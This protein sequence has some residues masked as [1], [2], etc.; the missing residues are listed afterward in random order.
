MIAIRLARPG[1]SEAIAA[2]YVPIVRDTV[3]SFEID[4]PTP[5]EMRQRIAATLV[6]H[7][8]LV[9]EQ[10]GAVVGYAYAS[11]HR[12]RSAYRWSCDVTAYMAEAARGKGTGMRLYAELFDI[13][14]A[15]G[16]HAAF[17]GISLPNAASV[18][19][20]EKAGF[21][22]VGIYSQVGYKHGAWHDVG[23]WQRRLVSAA[24]S[25]DEPRLLKDVLP[26]RTGA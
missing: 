8:W 23:W 14:S 2:I 19:L 10:D 9:A 17:A 4:P 13:L 12:T 22:P 26:G 21:E 16:F 20:H 24:G 1:D 6:T 18:A 3:I 11:Q 15:Q 5:A 25:P 7:P